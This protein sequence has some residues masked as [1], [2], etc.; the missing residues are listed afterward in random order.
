MIV[1][2]DPTTLKVAALWMAIGI[3]VY[4]FY[5]R[6]HSLVRKEAAAKK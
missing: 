4:Y 3:L 5:S 1:A 2:L 6:H